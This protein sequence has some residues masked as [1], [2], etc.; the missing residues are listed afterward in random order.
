M[1]RTPANAAT[2]PDWVTF[3][4]SGGCSSSVG[5]RG[6]QQFVNLG[7]GCTTGNTIHE[8]GHTV[9]M[10]HEQSRQDR[11]A[12]VTIQ[13]ANIE[14]GLEHNFDQ[15]ISDGDDVGPYDYG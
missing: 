7:G 14:A 11:D 10:W 12:F 13:W 15:H 8:I 1:A 6:G 4:P 3:R 9:G 5:R 2:F